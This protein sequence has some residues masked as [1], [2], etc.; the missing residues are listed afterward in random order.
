MFKLWNLQNIIF[1][2]LISGL[3]FP[4]S[5]QDNFLELKKINKEVIKVLKEKDINTLSKY[6]HPK[7]GILFAP[8]SDVAN[9]RDE[10]LVLKKKEL[11]KTYNKNKVLY[12]GSYDASTEPIN[13]TFSEYYDEFIYD[14]DF[15]DYEPNYDSLMGTG[16]TLENTNVLFPDSTVIEYYIPGT[17]D[18]EQGW[19]S[20]RLVYEVYKDE[21]YL[22]AII[23]NQWTI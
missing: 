19:K 17:E 15:I 10:Y 6:A 4:N 18:H 11:V 3:S 9:Y 16:L 22:V 2:F 20:L 7:K 12:W 21:Y 14:G 23:H 1:L 13:L 5:A 8:Y